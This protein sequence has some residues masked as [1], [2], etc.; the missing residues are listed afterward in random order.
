MLKPLTLICA[1]LMSQVAHSALEVFF[2]SGRK[3]YQTNEQIEVAVVRVSKESLSEATMQLKLRCDYGSEMTFAFRL[4]AVPAVEGEAKRTE[5]LRINGRLLRPGRYTL[6][7]S[8][9]GE[10]QRLEFELYSHIRKSSFRLIDWACRSRGEEQSLLGEDSVGFNLIYASYGGLSPDDS[11]RGGLDFMW[12]CTMGGGHQMDL[13]TECDWSDPYVL[14]GAIARVARRALKDRLLPNCIG[15]HFYDE[16][17]LTW[18]KHPVTGEWTPH[19]IKA[20]VRSFKSAYGVEPPEYYKLNPNDAADLQRWMNWGR[21][22][23]SLLEAAWRHSSFAVNQVRP[24]FICATQSQ[25]GWFAY[26]DGYYFNVVRSLPIISGH[27]GYDDGGYFLPPFYFEMGRARELNKPAW[28]LPTWYSEI[29]PNRYRMEVYL[30]FMNNLQGI[31]KPPDLQMH[32]PSTVRAADGVVEANKLLQRL[33][34]IFTTMPVTRPKVAVLY[35]MSQNLF[36]QAHDMQDNYDGGGQRWRIYMLYLASKLAHL[37]IQPVVE[38][39]VLDGTLALHHKAVILTG[40]NYLDPKVIAALEQFANSGGIIILTDDCKV[41]INGAVRLGCEPDISLLRRISQLWREGKHEEIAKLHLTG[42]Y[43]KAAEPLA[44]ALRSKL[45]QFGIMPIAECDNPGIVLSR[46]AYGDVEY[47]FAVNAAYDERVGSLNSIKSTVATIALP[48]DGRAI[49]DAV[50]SCVAAEFKRVSG[51]LVARLRF[52]AGQ[53]RAYAMTKRPIGGVQVKASVDAKDYTANGSPIKLRI[54]AAVVDDASR[55]IAGSMPMEV[56]VKDAF[57]E[58][59]YH[60]YRATE[61]GLLKLD[62][63]LAVNDAPGSWSVIVRELLSGKGSKTQFTFSPPRQCGAVAGLAGR[64]FHLPDDREHIFRFFRVH[65]HI[66]IVKGSSPFN[67]AAADRL[68]Q[69]LKPWG[70]RCNVI[71]ADEVQVRELSD[72]EASTWCGLNYAPSGAIKPGRT[73]DPS[74]VG[75]DVDSP[76]VLLG[77]ERDNKLIAFLL[78]QGFLPYTPTDDFP[79][80]SRSIVAWT[81][82][83]VSYGEEAV[84]LIARDPEGMS[85]A[86]GTLYEMMAGIEPL[87]PLVAPSAAESRYGAQTALKRVSGEL[88][89]QWKILLPDKV[90]SLKPIEGD[91]LVVLSQDGTL[92][93]VLSDGK[94]KWMRQ[95]EGGEFMLMDASPNGRMI[96]VG[97]TTYVHGF[98]RDGKALFKC[99]LAKGKPMTIANFVAVS[100][101]GEKVAI[102]VS[103]GRLIVLTLHG[104][105]LWSTVSNDEKPQPYLSGTFSKDGELLIAVT[106]TEAHV[107]TAAN[108]KLIR[109]I[110]GVNGRVPPLVIEKWLVLSDG[111]CKLKIFPINGALVSSAQVREVVLTKVGICA[112][113]QFGENV[114]VG[115]EVDGS[116]RVLKPFD[117]QVIREHKQPLRITKLIAT[118]KD[119]IAVAYW[120]GEV[121]VVNAHSGLQASKVFS[122]SLPDDIVGLCWLGRQLIIAASN[123]ELVALR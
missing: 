49:Y 98:D 58:V 33:G 60:L 76:A 43:L 110:E 24:D 72:E 23:L 50:R 108:G 51:K 15:V 87:M 81:R 20:Q 27:G 46:Q 56:I 25:Y 91:K 59:R 119:A 36:A 4:P 115:T 122:F 39:D 123:G 89:A 88:K 100:G 3:A 21:W 67:D 113:A 120:G 109:T 114:V 9:D 80:R 78:K 71:G 5:L 18:H 106:P 11:I 35:S 8:I 48:D 74:L 7:V 30:C 68:V 97:A 19:G 53:M 69:S 14:N 44:K 38:E 105:E 86:V 111:E 112:L 61:D 104:K 28:Y 6:E 121:K 17:G 73:N 13:R 103:D 118:T 99:D 83:G 93:L 75:F 66:V 85:E 84:V 107:Y 62:L 40:V 2:P 94:V 52:G 102:G 29:T 70:I 95:I 63:P 16:P 79:G 41:N 55:I 10:S 116:V 82:D 32:R 31:A 64:S 101:D 37:P 34:T 96:A 1:A 26:A 117:G 65:R 92:A 42:N 90:A 22:K 54:V 12:C 47:L 57:G 45:S 77:N